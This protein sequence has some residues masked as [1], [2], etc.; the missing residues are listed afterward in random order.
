MAILFNLFKIC[1]LQGSEG[2]YFDG[3]LQEKSIECPHCDYHCANITPDLKIHLQRKHQIG[4]DQP[5]PPLC[6]AECSFTTVS[7]KDL[8]QHEKFHKSGPELKLYCEE[9]CFVTDCQSRLKRHLLTHTRERPFSCA[10]CDYRATQKEHISRHMK[11]KHDAEAP[12]GQHRRTHSTHENGD[13]TEQVVPATGQQKRRTPLTDFCNKEKLFAC[14]F[15]TMSFAKL[16]NLYKHISVQHGNTET[17]GLHACVV[18]EY[19]ST[20]RNNLL[21]HMRKHNANASVEP[22][23][24]CK[25][26]SCVVCKFMHPKRQTLYNHMRKQHNMQIVV[27]RGNVHCLIDANDIADDDDTQLPATTVSSTDTEQVLISVDA[28]NAALL[29]MSPGSHTDTA[30]PGG[31]YGNSEA[32]NA[33]QKLQV[34]SQAEDNVPLE[35]VVLSEDIVV[36]TDHQKDTLIDQEVETA[37]DIQVCSEELSHLSSGDFVEINGDMY[38]VEFSNPK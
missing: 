7:R 33:V 23:A 4:T 9:C 10:L 30:S 34:L 13:S 32:I 35:G 21:V 5:Q 2:T 29:Q 15:C 3:V 36:L 22:P 11:A 12:V 37:T 38:K 18:C 26:Y 6:C 28:S 17:D 14:N 31:S 25:L 19:R 24:P 8:K 27:T 16:I 20:S 1:H